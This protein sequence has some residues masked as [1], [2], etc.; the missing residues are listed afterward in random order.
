MKLAG[1][2]QPG[3]AAPTV[4]FYLDDL[5]MTPP[6]AAQTGKI[7]ID[8]DLYDVDHIE[9]L[10]GPQ[11]TLYGSGSM[12][13][14]IRVATT[15]PKLGAY[16]ASV[17]AGVS[18]TEGGGL[19]GNVSAMVN[20]P[21]GDK[22][23]LRLVGADQERSG[24][25]DRITLA[26]FPFNPF[27]STVRG[28]VADAAVA[29]DKK[30]ANTEHM[31]GLRGAVLFE[32]T[33]DLTIVARALYQGIQMGAYDEFDFPPGSAHEA[34]YQAFDIP[35]PFTD[36]VSVFGLTATQNFGFAT[37]TSVTGYWARN[38]QQ[39][40]DASE[41]L[42]WNFGLVPLIPIAYSE[43]DKTRQFSEE[44][45]LASPEREQRLTWVVG[46]F[47]TSLRSLWAESN[48]NPSPEV[49]AQTP[50]LNPNGYIFDAHNPYHVDQTAGFADVSYAITQ[51]LKVSA[52]ARWNRYDSALINNEY[53]LGAPPFYAPGASL[54]TSTSASA[55]T[56]KFNISYE[57][58][59][60]LTLYATAS[61]G[62]RPGGLNQYLPAYCGA[63]PSAKS[64]GPDN[65]WNY[66]AG[67]KARLMAGRI[68]V[69]ADVYYDSWSQ[70]QQLLL[71][72]CGDEYY[73]NAGNGRTFG[74]EF[75]F[76]GKITQN[77]SLSVD[78]VYNDAEITH[79][80]AILAANIFDNAQP[81]TISTCSSVAKCTVPILNVPK[82]TAN[83]SL[84]YT[85]P[86]FGAY[87]FTARIVDSYV[88]P[89][90]DESF[91][92]IINLPIY[93]IVNIRFGIDNR[94]WSANLFVNNLTNARPW[95]SSNNTSFQFNSPTY[96]RISTDQPLTGGVEIS[97]HY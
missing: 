65:V 92:P 79:P 5:P 52:G 2:H 47:Y 58:N 38:E 39:T 62:F 44:L 70:I 77:L 74:P 25:I 54:R 53:G 40:Q 83:A 96:V 28:D 6:A 13:G 4:G 67:E 22:V 46:L 97:Y 37:L 88:G 9:V 45:R 91:Y 64:Y 19:N 23:A 82:Y 34:R 63:P 24:W 69:N 81:G 11:G 80:S 75:E 84:T 57:P 86:I 17:Q 20:I 1:C 61:Q 72:Q 66:E 30:D 12:G 85:K 50:G 94:K 55:V 59:R 8:P 18:G 93:D 35:E 15:L 16:D 29:S 87:I 76:I 73:A 56:P 27:P 49:T 89:V 36:W 60:D 41:N 10:R 26:D 33:N 68:T 42:G 95:L 90:V 31:G 3:G 21:L 7:V 71:L 14:T 78:G 32:P 51:A 43:I 48:A